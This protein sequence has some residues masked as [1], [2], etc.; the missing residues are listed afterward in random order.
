MNTIQSIALSITSSPSQ[1]RMLAFLLRAGKY[2]KFPDTF[3]LNGTSGFYRIKNVYYMGEIVYT[4][5]K[6][7]VQMNI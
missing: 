6:Y 2:G 7:D 3:E 5:C 1:I 4:I